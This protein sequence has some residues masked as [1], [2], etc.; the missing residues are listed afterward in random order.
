MRFTPT[1]EQKKSLVLTIIFYAF[2]LSLLFFIRFWPPAS[3]TEFAG[4]GGGGG[5]AINFGESDFGSGKSTKN[6]NTLSEK[7]TK[8]KAI[9]AEEEVISQEN[10]NEES[11]VIPKKTI[12][13]S[14]AV[15]VEKEVAKVIENKPKVSKTT[16]D[17][18]A[19]LLK[20][21]NKDGDGN[22]KTAGNKGKS[23][24]SL[25]ANG[26]GTTGGSG[27]GTG[28]GNGSGNGIGSG[29][30]YGAGSGGGSGNGIGGGYSLGNRK[31]VSKPAPKYN[32]NEIGK[33]VVEVTVDKNGQTINAVVGIKG[34]TNTAKCLLD[35]AKIAAMNTKWESSSDAPEKQVGKIIYNFNLN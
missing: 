12:I 23:N 2:L 15:V 29:S 22:D 1:S 24:G 28:G 5:V 32:C 11:V 9:T 17:V 18:L 10:T 8:T 14:K 19:T 3:I 33:V 16:N 34:T 20:G 13:K 4:G 25:G 26:Y 6:D 21:S 35:Q 31:A 27:N 7:A 30:G